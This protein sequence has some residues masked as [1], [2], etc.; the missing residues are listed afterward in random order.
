VALVEMDESIRMIGPMDGADPGEI[1][2]GARV[3]TRFVNR[4]GVAGYRFVLTDG[5]R[6]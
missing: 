1:R 6:P 3:D 2:I 5:A 4:N